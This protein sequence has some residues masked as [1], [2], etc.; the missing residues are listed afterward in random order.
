MNYSFRFILFVF[1]SFFRVWQ[2]KIIKCSELRVP[3]SDILSQHRLIL[4]AQET[5]FILEREDERSHGATK[6]RNDKD[7]FED[8]KW[9]EDVKCKGS[10]TGNDKEAIHWISWSGKFVAGPVQSKQFEKFLVVVETHLH[11]SEIRHEFIVLVALDKVFER[12]FLFAFWLLESF[13]NIFHFKL[14]I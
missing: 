1:L 4:P 3:I 6:C 7:S 13:L 9:T 2:L 14:I 11:N 8:R 5:K 10:H 12:I